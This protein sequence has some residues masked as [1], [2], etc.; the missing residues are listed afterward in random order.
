MGTRTQDTLLY[1]FCG[2]DL[3]FCNLLVETS[4][5]SAP[6]FPLAQFL[7]YRS[8]LTGRDTGDKYFGTGIFVATTSS[9]KQ[10]NFD[11]SIVL[12]SRL[13]SDLRDPFSPRHEPRTNIKTLWLPEGKQFRSWCRST[14]GLKFPSCWI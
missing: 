1:S 12:L 13:A 6:F 2:V 3:C 10:A 8:T 9:S 11:F 4:L 7:S 5:L 14:V